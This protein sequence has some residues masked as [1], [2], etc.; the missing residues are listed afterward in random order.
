MAGLCSLHSLLPECEICVSNLARALAEAD[1]EGHTA[2]K[3]QEKSGKSHIR[4]V[5]E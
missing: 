2:K 1:V 3:L 4:G 5:W